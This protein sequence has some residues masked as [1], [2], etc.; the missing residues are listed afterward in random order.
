MHI[1]NTIS[2]NVSKCY[3]FVIRVGFPQVW[4]I[5][6]SS[7]TNQSVKH[8]PKYCPLFLKYWTVFFTKG[9]VVLDFCVLKFCLFQSCSG[10]TDQLYCSQHQSETGRM[11]GPATYWCPLT[12]VHECF[13]DY[14]PYLNQTWHIHIFH[15]LCKFGCHFSEIS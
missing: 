3:Y 10:P 12:T 6:G 1:I 15:I 14:M 9:E 5:R 13:I 8:F 4:R 7:K 11:R 2:L